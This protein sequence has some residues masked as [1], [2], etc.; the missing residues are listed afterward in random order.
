MMLVLLNTKLLNMC[1]GRFKYHNET[2]AQEKGEQFTFS[3]LYCEYSLPEEQVSPLPFPVL[4][5][6]PFWL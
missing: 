3:I 2:T 1:Y 5:L 4:S 6:G